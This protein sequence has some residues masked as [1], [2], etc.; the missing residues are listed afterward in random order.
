MPTN[1]RKKGFILLLVIAMIPLVGMVVAILTANSKVLTIKSR[2]AVLQVKA[3]NACKS[4]RAWAYHHPA[5]IRQLEHGSPHILILQ[6][7]P[8]VTCRLERVEDPQIGTTIKITG[9]AEGGHYAASCVEI[10]GFQTF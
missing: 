3:D 4:G 7:G 8:K 6:D 1:K 10:L 9:Q 5:N 2:Q